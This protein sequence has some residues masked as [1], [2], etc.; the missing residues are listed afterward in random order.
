MAQGTLPSAPASE[1]TK[2]R[3][4]LFKEVER[5]RQVIL[6]TVRRGDDPPLSYQAGT[7]VF[8]QGEQAIAGFAVERGCV[9]VGHLMEDGSDVV[10]KVARPGDFVGIVE[11]LID[12]AHTRYALVVKDALV[13]RLDQNKIYSLLESD[14]DFARAM[15]ITPSVGFLL[16]QLSVAGLRAGP[17]RAR[18][19][20]LLMRLAHETDLGCRDGNVIE[21]E[22]DQEEMASIIGTTRQS[23]SSLL[24]ALKHDG[25]IR[26]NHG[27]IEIPS[28]DAVLTWASMSTHTSLRPDRR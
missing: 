16:S 14:R 17:V 12:V 23:V 20:Q 18:L 7:F 11:T 6:T 8:H 9:K 28:W 2:L 25:L 5:A 10:L 13:W 19:V 27:T 22:L 3:T 24:S 26:M 4:A 1:D 21:L 15:L